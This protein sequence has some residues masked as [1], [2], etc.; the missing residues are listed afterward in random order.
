MNRATRTAIVAAILIAPLMMAFPYQP[1]TASPTFE[2]ASVKPY[3]DGGGG[4][5]GA[6]IVGG[7]CRG[8]D[9]PAPG[10]P[11]SPTPTT[12]TIGGPPPGA[13]AGPAGAALGG[14]AFGPPSTPVGRCVYT[15][16]TLKMLI[17]AAYRLTAMGGSL[18][19]LLSGGPGWIA[20]DAFDVEAKAEDPAHT[21]QDQLRVMLQNL[22]VERFKMKFHREKK[23]TQ[24]FDLVVA[25]NGLKMKTVEG[26]DKSPGGMSMSFGNPAN[27]GMASTN[28]PRATIA[29][30]VSFLS[31]RLGRAIQDKTGLTGVY[32]FSLNWT[33]GEGES[34]GLAGL[35]FQPPPG[36][37]PTASEPGVSIFTALQEQMGLRLETSKVQID[38]MVIDSAEKPDQQ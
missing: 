25:K 21:S 5:P 22:L 34:N 2:V 32:S 8:V 18:D 10:G 28:S 11:G 24:G 37:V 29:N 20:T 12:V 9:S 27:G 14:R 6:V 26:D 23:E 7:G 30:I 13:G 3:K 4:P 31:G 35:A 16:M 15:R 1:Q 17:N 38:A 36:A 19:Q 33:P